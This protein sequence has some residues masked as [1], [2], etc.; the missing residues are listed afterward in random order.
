MNADGSHHLRN[1]GACTSLIETR[2]V[3]SSAERISYS[4]RLQ[5]A[6]SYRAADPTDKSEHARNSDF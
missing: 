6:P 3:I 2:T 4:S 5:V 1:G